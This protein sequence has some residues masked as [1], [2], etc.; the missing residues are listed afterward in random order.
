V[1]VE[2]TLRVDPIPEQT[3]WFAALFPS[4]EAGVDATRRLASESPLPAVLRVSDGA[5][6]DLTLAES[7]WEA[8]GPREWLRRIAAVA[9]RFHSAGPRTSCLLIASYEGSREEVANGAKR[10]RSLRKQFS[11][12][13]LPTRV[14]RAW[15]ESRFRTPYLRDDLVEG[16]WFVETFETFVSWGG[17]PKVKG[18]AEGAVRRWA[19]ARGVRAYVGGHLSH[20]S[21][22]GT[23]LYFTVIAP[24]K[25]GE[26]EI[27][28]EAFK[29]VTAEAVVSAG[30]PVS[31]HHG[32]GRY[33]RPWANRSLPPEWLTGLKSLK[34]RW[35]PNGIMNPGKMLPER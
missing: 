16:N 34:E 4:W 26:E 24:Q 5:E 7:G 33:H 14:G 35:D 2:A 31:H 32:I 22:D 28:W 15:E 23:A 8:G 19:D 10:F 29:Q 25:P 20:P 13:W 12:A 9:L 30:G 21:V 27:A 17:L 3:H 11:A 6:T 18:A 1:I